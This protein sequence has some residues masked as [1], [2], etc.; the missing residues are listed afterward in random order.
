MPDPVTVMTAADATAI[1][2]PVLGL[3]QLTKWLIQRGNGGVRWLG[4]V[5][6]FVYA[7]LAEGLW[8]VSYAWPPPQTMAFSIFANW[9]GITLAASGLYGFTRTMDRPAD[10]R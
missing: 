4:P 7:A 9:V 8:L 6:I 10:S 3:A 1:S 2:V 5:T